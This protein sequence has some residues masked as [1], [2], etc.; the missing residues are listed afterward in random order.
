MYCVVYFHTEPKGI[1]AYFSNEQLLL[2]ANKADSMCHWPEDISI[3]LARHLCDP[4][5]ADL[6]F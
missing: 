4:T 2:L 3:R 6:G 5:G 1:A